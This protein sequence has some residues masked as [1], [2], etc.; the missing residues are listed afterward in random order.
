MLNWFAHRLKEMQER[1][2]EKGFTLIE[3]LVVVIIIGILAAIAIPVFLAQ[4]N[5]AREA[6]IES[7]LRNFAAAATACSAAN[8]GSYAPCTKPVLDGA[9]Y[10]A[11]ETDGVTVTV[12]ANTAT[13]WTA[14]STHA[15]LPAGTIANFS[16]VGANAGEVVLTRP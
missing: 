10:N 1:D 5:G 9:P 16:T 7:D 15:D 14:N 3:L 2:D 12:T 4:R 8:D 6:A 13:E 11:A